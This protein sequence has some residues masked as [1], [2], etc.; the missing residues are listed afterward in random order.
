MPKN[1]KRKRS[2]FAPFKSKAKKGLISNINSAAL[3]IYRGPAQL[4]GSA[5]QDRRTRVNL[6]FES[7][8]SSSGAGVIANVL[9]FSSAFNEWSSLAAI[10]EEFRVLS[11]SA[12][13]L[14]SNKYTKITT[15]CRPGYIIIDRT[16]NAALASRAA[17][18]EHESSNLVNLEDSWQKKVDMSNA[19]ESQFQPTTGITATFWIKMY[20]D[21]LSISTEYGVIKQIALVEFR[22]RF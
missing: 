5:R 2:R 15:N 16:T 4:P 7:V 21:A 11:L 12:H 19:V 10:Y 6:Y 8:L 18:L 13:F 17:A 3:Q 9:N 20:F 1:F 14:A 22:G